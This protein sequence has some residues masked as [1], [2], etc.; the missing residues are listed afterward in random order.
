[1]SE[2][3]YDVVVVGGGAAGLSAG[4]VLAQAQCR[5]A[6]VDAGVPRNR[7]DDRMHGYLSRDGIAPQEFLRLGRQE[8]EDAGGELIEAR[9]TGAE[10]EGD[11]QAPRFTLHTDRRHVLRTRRV[12]VA[13]GLT[14]ELPAVEGLE[15]YWGHAVFHCPYCHG[16]QITS[17]LVVGVLAV[18]PDSVME[19]HLLLQWADQVFSCGPEPMFRPLRRE[20]L[21]NRFAR[22][23]GEGDPIG[24]MLSP[25]MNN[26]DAVVLQ[27]TATG[28]LQ[29]GP[30]H[31]PDTAFPGQPGTVA[32]AGHRTTYLA[33]FR[34]IANLSRGDEITL[35]MPYGRFVYRVEKHEIVTPD[36][37][38]VIDDVGYPRLVLSAC[39][40]LYSA[41]ERYIIFARLTEI[42]LRI[43]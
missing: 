8:V 6:V 21:A 22:G 14:D 41:A 17:D 2:D 11:E 33:P 1:M 19:A 31:Y 16:V 23:V 35:E 18:G 39:H 15:P 36:R 25:E 34:Q 26:L 29:Q 13:T 20:V 37:V 40:P 5:M 38:D 27:G 28:T 12:V 9:V 30:G 10:R 3:L 7:F 4:L 43:G 42:T 32:I 24:R